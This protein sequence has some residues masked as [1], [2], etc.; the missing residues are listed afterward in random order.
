MRDAVRWIGLLLV[1]GLASAPVL[2]VDGRDLL[3]PERAFPVTARQSGAGMVSLAWDIA[4]GYYLYRSKFKFA[5]RTP[6]VRLGEPVFPA[7]YKKQDAFFGEVETYRGHVEV[8]LPLVAESALPESLEL[9]VTVQGCADAGVCFPPYQRR[10]GVTTAAIGGGGAFTRLAGALRGIGSGPANGDLLPADQAFRFF[11]E[12]PTGD[13]LRLSW[14]IAPGYYLYREKFRIVLRDSEGV[15]LG[16]YAF[17]RGEPKIDEEFGAVEI[18]HGEVA[19]DI[20]LV[21]TDSG[22]RTLTLEAGFQG[23][24]ERGVCYPPMA[25]TVELALPAAAE[26]KSVSAVAGAT[27]IT[28]QDRIADG[29]WRGSL[30]LNMLSFLGFG[31]LLAFTPCIF[32]MI[33]ILS[34]VIVGHGHAITTRRAFSLSLAYVLAHALAYTGFGVL[35]A[36]FGANLQATLQNPWAIGAFSGLFV[37]LALSMFGFYQLQL[38][39]ALQSRIAALSSRQQA[40]SLA[41]AA[42]MGLLSAGLVG[43]C[44]AAPLAGALIYIGRSGDALLG[45]VALFSLG[46]GMGLPLLA[47]GTSA[48]KLLPKAGMWMNAVKSVFGVAMLAVAVSMLE[49][50][51][52]LSLAML[53]WALLLIVP[54]VYMGA[55]DALPAG[56]S[57]WR[58]LWKGLGVAMA[59]Y[60]V[61]MLLG[62]AAGSRDPLQPLRGVAA[63]PAAVADA[64]PPPFLRVASLA[65]LEAR[66]DEAASAGRWA[67]LD[68]YADWC[69]SCKEMERH[70]FSDPAVKAKLKEMVLLKADIT[71]NGD[72]DQAL[73]RR[74][75]LV[76]PPAT[77][78][79]GPDRSERKPFRLVG[80]TESEKFVHH[81]ER[82]FD[83]VR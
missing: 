2:A 65:E 21:R 64:G 29:L 49:R 74:F 41:G 73:L 56:A 3:S 59:V 83:G 22:P 47:I 44:V 67:M 38:P 24:A 23:C 35:A 71:E 1:F 58:K 81:L 32:P 72:E 17:P 25:K 70:T 48:G 7:G 54:A 4:D 80:F 40:G 46:L 75:G 8:Q 60:G 12:A 37:V 57:G 51:V 77:L 15:A 61:F 68:F 34:G 16:G 33:P 31:V 50:I 52:P 76:G 6:G 43:P 69:V 14:Q 53:M 5:S 19:V 62:V 55:L 42:V 82:L 63:P 45:G 10:I 66:L 13:V 30:W 20:P 28:E 39:I 36:L 79:F 11:A 26:G 78:F 9:E 27:V 18:F